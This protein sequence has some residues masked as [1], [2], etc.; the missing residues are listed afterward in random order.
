MWLDAP[1]EHLCAHGRARRGRRG[2]V[3]P[4]VLGQWQETQTDDFAVVRV[5]QVLDGIPH[6]A[7]RIQRTLPESRHA[8]VYDL[9]TGLLLFKNAAVL[10]GDTTFVSQIFYKVSRPLPFVGQGNLLPLWLRSGVQLNYRGTY[11]ARVEGKF[12]FS[13][14][15]RAGIEIQQVDESWFL[16]RQTT[17]LSSLNGLPPTVEVATLVGGGTLFIDPHAL[18]RLMPETVLDTDPITGATLKVVA[19]GSSVI[20]V[21]SAGNQSVTEFTYAAAV[22]LMTRFRSWDSTDPLYS[23][24]SD[25]VLDAM[26]DRTLP[27]RLAIRRDERG[28]VR[29]GSFPRSWRQIHRLERNRHDGG[30]VNRR[31]R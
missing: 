28:G 12:P 4:Q 17:S 19:Q 30:S 8:S 9:N 23:L 25:L 1:S 11:T 27:P 21:A 15:L 13:L 3:H 6:P 31:W 5:T 7:I 14:P 2:W 26:P 22:G 18:E 24:S 10:T 20:L 29:R 16:Y